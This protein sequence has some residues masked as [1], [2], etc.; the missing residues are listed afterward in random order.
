MRERVHDPRAMLTASANDNHVLRHDDRC[1]KGKNQGKE[2][3]LVRRILE[4]SA[5]N[6]SLCSSGT[7][8]DALLLVAASEC[9]IHL[10]NNYALARS[11]VEPAANHEW[12]VC[13]R[14]VFHSVHDV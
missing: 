10:G 8:M 3:G 13:P 14:P 7:T 6:W 11:N 4:K 1:K 5:E 9:A 12:H 2:G